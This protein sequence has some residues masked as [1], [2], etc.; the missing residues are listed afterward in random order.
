MTAIGRTAA[1]AALA[2]CAGTGAAFAQTVSAPQAACLVLDGVFEGVKRFERKCEVRAEQKMLL[3]FIDL[4][5]D[6]SAELCT[7]MAKM[8]RDEDM[9]VGQGWTL[10]MYAPK[11]L[12]APRAACRL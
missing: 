8:L 2:L 1:V 5:Q 11:Q 3:A 10:R 6:V 4:P 9:R 7:A 12:D